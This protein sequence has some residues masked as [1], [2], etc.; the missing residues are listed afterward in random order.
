MTIIQR[1]TTISGSTGGAT[2]LTLTRTNNPTTGD[3]MVVWGMAVFANTLTISDNFGDGVGWTDI[4]GTP[5]GAV[6]NNTRIFGW[7]KTIGASVT[8]KVVTLTNSSSG[9]I[10]GSATE[11]YSDVSATF[12]FQFNTATGVSA[13]PTSGNITLS[14]TG[15]WVVNGAISTYYSTLAPSGGYTE[16]ATN[17]PY[18]EFSVVDQVFAAATTTAA[19]WTTTSYDYGAAAIAIKA[20]TLGPQVTAATSNP[21]HQSTGN[22]VTGSGFKAVQGAGYL[23]IGGQVQT[24]TAWSDTSITYTA[25][26]GVNLNNVGVNLIVTD[27]DALSSGA[28][29]LTGFRPAAGWTYVT[30]TSIWPVVDERIHS[31]TDL[32]IGNQIEWD[33][34]TIAIDASGQPLWPPGTANSYTFNSRVGVTSDGWGSSA[35]QTL[36][37][38]LAAN[39][40]R[41]FRPFCVRIGR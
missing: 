13:T 12:S 4:T 1:D 27:S 22:T 7:Y 36:N 16:L 15:S 38:P 37:A 30:L 11:Y 33:D 28:W 26:R 19:S 40:A 25:D 8:N 32:A 39:M 35:V 23:T 41:I 6:S 18:R 34:V 5:I 21:I 24:I 31:L 17:N 29:A 10:S 9:I 3:I 14:G 20:T 2:T